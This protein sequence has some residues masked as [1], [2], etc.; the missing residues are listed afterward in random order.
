MISIIVIEREPITIN[1]KYGFALII[2][3]LGEYLCG[4]I[5]WILYHQNLLYLHKDKHWIVISTILV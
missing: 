1:Q 4:S 2:W 5:S 3:V